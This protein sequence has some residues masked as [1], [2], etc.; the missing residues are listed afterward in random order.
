MDSEDDSENVARA[1][2]SARRACLAWAGHSIKERLRIIRRVRQLIARDSEAFAADLADRRPAA[3]TLVSEVLPLAEAARFLEGH[4][5]ALLA[6]RTLRRGRPLWLL[7]VRAEIRRE[8]LGAVLILA[9]SNY[10]LFLPGAQSLQALAAGNAVCV[11]PAPGCSK[12]MSR[13]AALLAEAG[14]PDGVLTVLDESVE[15]AAAA[16]R[17]G[18]DRIV[19]TGSAETG[20]RVLAAAAARLTPTT[21]ELSGNDPVFVL[22]GADIDMV[23]SCLAYSLRLNGGATCIAPRRVFVL[24]AVAQALEQALQ[25]RIDTIGPA[26]V[27]ERVRV[28][29]QGLL[30]EAEAAG[31]RVLAWPGAERV[32]PVIVAD[33]PLGLR[34]LREDVFAPVLAI[35]PVLDMEQALVVAKDCR[36]ALGASIFGPPAEAM[37]LAARVNAGAVVINDVIVPTAD[38]RLPFGGRGESGFGVTRGAE[39]LLE[40]TVLK[41]ISTRSGRARPHLAAPRSKD[42]PRFAAMIRLL[43]GGGLSRFS[44]SAR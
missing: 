30:H 23:A 2:L 42:A 19:L 11:K 15:T 28:Q 6:P 9:P 21:M 37:L 10:P 16:V 25:A 18:F 40:M 24:H 17:A 27:P 1:L 26:A 38:P 34:L 20:R 32:P 31:A 33:A 4:A 44:R 14:L 8:P 39:G 29:L 13:L 43:H 36:Y 3:E 22:P 12:P 41:T 5:A 7:G 35:V